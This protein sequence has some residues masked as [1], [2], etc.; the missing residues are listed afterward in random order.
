[1]LERLKSLNTFV[2]FKEVSSEKVVVLLGLFD[3]KFYT[4]SNLGVKIRMLFFKVM[5]R[6]KS[7]VLLN[8]HKIE[9]IF[10]IIIFT[11]LIYK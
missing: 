2:I 8:H 7:G 11:I 10:W 1:M 5:S 4:F 6:E 3:F 9:E